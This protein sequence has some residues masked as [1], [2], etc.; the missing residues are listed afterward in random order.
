MAST[1]ALAA[2]CSGDAVEEYTSVFSEKDKGKQ[3]QA[4]TRRRAKK[5]LLNLCEPERLEN[6]RTG[7]YW[8]CD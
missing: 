1:T 5:V 3:V 8:E 6:L 7:H 4:E 2:S